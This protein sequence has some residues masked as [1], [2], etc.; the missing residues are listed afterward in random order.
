MLLNKLEK[1]RKYQ[2]SISIKGWEAD[3]NLHDIGLYFTDSMIFSARDTVMQPA[4]YVNFLDAKVKILKNG[5]FRLDKQFLAAD[6]Y[7]CLIVGNFSSRN[8]QEIARQRATKSAYLGDLVD[9]IEIKPIENIACENCENIKDSLY[10]ITRRH[11]GMDLP[12]IAPDTSPVIIKANKIDTIVLKDILFAIDS[13]KLIDTAGFENYRNVF[14]GKDIRKI[15]IIGYTDDVGTAEYN[16]ALASKRAIEI[17]RQISMRFNIPASL[18]E[19]EG[20]G[21][22]TKYAEQERNRRVEIYVQY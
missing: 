9:D 12:V 1:G 2:I 17:G 16:Q 22:S 13:Y 8:Y 21:I 10:S 3:P 19:C 20:R 6:N 7:Q 15:R 18:I 4:D 11:S 5:W 14:G